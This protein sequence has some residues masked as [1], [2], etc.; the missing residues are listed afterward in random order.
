MERKQADVKRKLEKIV[1]R[2][3]EWAW[4]LNTTTI[5]SKQIL[6][7][8]LDSL[9]FQIRYGCDYALCT[10]PTC[11]SCRRRCKSAPARRPTELTAWIQAFSLAEVGQGEVESRIC[12]RI[13]SIIKSHQRRIAAEGFKNVAQGRKDTKSLPQNLFE[14]IPQI[15]YSDARPTRR[16]TSQQSSDEHIKTGNQSSSESGGRIVILQGHK[17]SR[18]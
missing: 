16:L 9:Y 8:C 15:L 10:I 6:T 18:G 13:S 11:Y 17:S 5:Q 14:R 12:P 3:G 7:A 2:Y 4:K 1:F